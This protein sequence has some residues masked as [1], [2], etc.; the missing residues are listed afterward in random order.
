M[1]IPL[2]QNT[3]SQEIPLGYFLDSINGDDEETGLTITNTNIKLWKYGATTIVS[4]NSGGATHIASGIYYCVL[5]NTDTDTL[6]GLNIFVHVSGA[7]A[8][9]VECVV[10]PANIFDSLFLGTD[11]LH[12]D[13]T[14]IGGAAQSATDLKDFADE[15]YDPATNKVQGVVLTDTCAGM[16]AEMKAEINAEVVDVIKTDVIA[17]MAQGTPSATPTLEDAIMYL[18]MHW[19][20]ETTTTN[21]THS[22]KNDGGTVIAK[23]T[24]SDDNTTFTKGEY[25]TGP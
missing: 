4:K 18:Y 16:S 19:R 21:S 13:L 23:S 1:T 2:R 9:K 22:L 11:V 15:G 10:Y 7:L 17:E 5:D 25:V 20:N 14:Q 24:I 6:G 12:A 8:I 3:S